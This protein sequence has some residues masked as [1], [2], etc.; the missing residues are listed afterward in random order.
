MIRTLL[1]KSRL[2]TLI[3]IVA[4]VIAGCAAQTQ[5][6]RHF[7]F[8]KTLEEN[9]KLE[10]HVMT[11]NDDFELY[12]RRVGEPKRAV[13]VWI[14]GTPGAWNDIGKLMVKEDFTDSTLFVSIDRPGWG[15][16]QY[17]DNPRLVTDFT[18]IA[19]LI[20]PLLHEL[21]EEAPDVPLILAGHSWGGS[22]V[23]GVAKE[24]PDCVD[25]LAIFAAGL[26][27]D[28][29]KPRWYNRFAKTYLGK[30][31]LGKSMLDAN[32]EMYAL[33]PE[34]EELL[35]HW[36]N[37]ELPTVVVQGMKDP[38]VSPRN[39]EFAEE[40]LNPENSHVLKIEKQDHFLHINGVDLIER[41]LLAVADNEL[42]NCRT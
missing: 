42:Q 39:A 6:N 17:I 27:P 7:E 38:L 37:I 23:P 21:R 10:P 14:H 24:F 20:R 30:R 1:R 8:M 28:L 41:C 33:S 16:S 3:A 25:G 2:I 12:Y 34:M 13:V 19:E 26:D 40:V 4:V 31:I 18:Q 29:T 5:L 35:P 32:V 9:E 36:Q 15:R 11:V 22:V